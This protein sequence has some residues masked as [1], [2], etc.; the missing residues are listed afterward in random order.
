[1]E[2]RLPQGWAE[3]SLLEFTTVLLLDGPCKSIFL[4]VISSSASASLFYI[5]ASITEIINRPSMIIIFLGDVSDM[6]NSIFYHMKSH[7]N[8]SWY[9]RGTKEVEREFEARTQLCYTNWGCWNS[10]LDRSKILWNK[11]KD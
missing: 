8:H 7:R 3:Q 4:S 10:I 11:I 2:S 6:I 1:M 9:L 5:A